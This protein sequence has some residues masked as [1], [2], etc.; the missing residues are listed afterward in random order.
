MSKMIKRVIVSTDSAEIADIAVKYGAEAPF[1]RPSEFAQDDSSDFEY[2]EHLI[3]FMENVEGES[4][5]YLVHLRPTTPLRDLKVVEDGINYI[6]NTP[7]ATSLRSVSPVT[8]P[9]EK[10]FKMEGLYLKGFFDNDPRPEY[11]NLPRQVFP[12]TYLPNGQVDVVRAST[13]KKGLIHG[14]KM[15]GFI[16]EPV[17]DID[18]ERDFHNASMALNDERFAD[19]LKFMGLTYG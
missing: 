4:F 7:H 10:I 13:I 3:D 12:Q 14:D 1:I 16:T 9:P 17:P 5:E 11:Y 8:Q 6:L 2:L 15:L 19:L 18:N